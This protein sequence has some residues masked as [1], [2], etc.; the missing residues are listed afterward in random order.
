MLFVTKA[1]PEP[2]YAEQQDCSPAFLLVKN[3]HQHVQGTGIL[4]RIHMLL[5]ILA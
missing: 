4:P 2:L 3:L 5:E 1:L